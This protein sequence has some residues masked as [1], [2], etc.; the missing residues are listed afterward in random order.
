M[1]EQRGARPHDLDRPVATFHRS[2]DA[3]LACGAVND[4]MAL[5]LLQDRLAE[6]LALIEN[7][8][9]NPTNPTWKDLA[10]IRAVLT[11]RDPAP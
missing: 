11:G 4:R 6:A 2:E 7:L 5:A 10:R 8:A 9:S 1:Y 3:R